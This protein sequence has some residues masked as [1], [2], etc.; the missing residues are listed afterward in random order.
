M[1]KPSRLLICEGNDDVAFFQRLIVSRS[2]PR[3]RIKH[4]GESRRKRGGNTRFTTVLEAAKFE[5]GVR[6]ILVVADNDN[7]PELSFANV[8]RQ[9]K[10]AYDDEK[11]PAEPLIKV[12]LE[13]SITVLMIPWANEKGCLETLCLNA[14]RSVNAEIAEN[15][16]RFLA[17]V[18]TENWD[19]DVRKDKMWLRSMLAVSH[20]RDPFVFL[21][22]VF[23]EQRED[24][25]LIP[26]NHR[27]FDA[28]ADVLQNF[29]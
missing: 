14:A 27:R 9:I 19:S 8:C 26:L 22:N 10:K 28:I 2:L 17:L 13:P 20:E 29:R 7:N 3:F 23:R 24:R 18:R 6:D 15:V 1:A 4:T 5:E 21:G 16:D 12:S 11:V 25:L